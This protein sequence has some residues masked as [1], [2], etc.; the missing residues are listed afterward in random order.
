MI[1]IQYPHGTSDI[2]KERLRIRDHQLI[3][4]ALFTTGT[5]SPRNFIGH[6]AGT[7][8]AKIAQQSFTAEKRRFGLDMYL[9]D[10]VDHR[11]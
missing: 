4:R 5:S 8:T 10:Y 1:L 3:V 6:L 2:A 11:Q 9:A 7:I